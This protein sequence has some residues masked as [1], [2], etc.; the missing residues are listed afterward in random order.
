MFRLTEP[1]LHH[2]DG[3]NR[4]DRFHDMQITQRNPRVKVGEDFEE[5]VK[6][7]R[8][9]ELIFHIFCGLKKCLCAEPEVSWKRD[10]GSHTIAGLHSS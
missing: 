9:K 6:E 10:L 2:W 5:T 3:F 8:S 4:E 1:R 7:G